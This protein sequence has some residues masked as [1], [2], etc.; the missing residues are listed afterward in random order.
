MW[1]HIRTNDNAQHRGI[2]GTKYS[3]RDCSI[4]TVV[5]GTQGSAA[6]YK[7]RQLDALSHFFIARKH[8]KQTM[9]FYTAFPIQI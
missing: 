4:H 8:R 6:V 2:I 3:I 1:T 7:N 9:D 5:A